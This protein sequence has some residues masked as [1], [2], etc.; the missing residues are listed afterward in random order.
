MPVGAQPGALYVEQGELPNRGTA[1]RAAG[2]EARRNA[3]SWGQW[4][5]AQLGGGRGAVSGQL[6]RSQT[7][8]VSRG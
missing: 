1:R 3:A 4:C 6:E 2:V 7:Q 8:T 5:R